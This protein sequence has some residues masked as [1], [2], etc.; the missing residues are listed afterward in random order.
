MITRPLELRSRLSPPPRHLDVFHWVTALAIVM[1]FGLL[2]SRFVLAPGLAIGVGTRQTS[3][4]G[5]GSAREEAMPASVV[6]SFR[7]ENV[8]LFEG[9]VYSM[10]ELGRAMKAYADKHP[11]S[12]MLAHFDRQVSV[13]SLIELTQL[14]KA[15]GF[16]QIQLAA[17]SA[18][19][20]GNSNP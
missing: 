13:Q 4:P 6:V 19:A 17:E 18:K 1:F 15:S 20:S 16:A 9:G 10:K 5:Y 8:I 14:A 7:R 3:L 2:G 12:V 11:G